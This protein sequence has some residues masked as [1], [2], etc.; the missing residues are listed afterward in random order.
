MQGAAGAAPQ[1]QGETMHTSRI[2]LFAAVAC[3]AVSPAKAACN[4]TQSGLLSHDESDCASAATV[5]SQ[6][7]Q[8]S[9][10]QSGKA[11]KSYVDNGNAVQNAFIIGNYVLD[12]F[13]QDQLDEHEDRLDA[14]KKAI[15][16]NYQWDAKQQKQITRLERS[17]GKQWKAIGGLKHENKQ[18]WYAIHDLKEWNED[19]DIRLDAHQAILSQHSKEIGQI[20]GRLDKHEKGLAIAMA[21]PDAYLQQNENFAIA[22]NLGFFDDQ[23]ALAFAAIGRINQTWS[24]N[25]GI[26]SDTG[27]EEVGGRV[28]VRAGW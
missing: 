12:G 3:L 14:H 19:Q 20:N 23:T 27:F 28:G 4:V 26:G 11:D 8:I 22:G 10:L 15:V 21:M 18:Q 25:A 24:V 17:D 9:A 1:Q 2:A 16:H 6:G 5:A 7:N 13:Q